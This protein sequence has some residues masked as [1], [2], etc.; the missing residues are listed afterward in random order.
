MKEGDIVKGMT[1]EQVRVIMLDKNA[2]SAEPD[3]KEQIEDGERWFFESESHT[4]RI[5]FAGSRVQTYKRVS[6]DTSGMR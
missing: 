4:Y 1:K 6:K 2:F 5:T 3:H